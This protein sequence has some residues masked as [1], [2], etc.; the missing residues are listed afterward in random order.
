MIDRVD[1]DRDRNVAVAGEA[2]GVLDSGGVVPVD[3]QQLGTTDLVRGDL[4]RL[5]LEA[6]RTLPEDRALAGS[7]VDEDIRRLIGAV[8]AQLNMGDVDPRGAH[9]V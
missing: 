7:L 3:V 6:F 9:V 1:I 4:R 2:G 8:L 5:D